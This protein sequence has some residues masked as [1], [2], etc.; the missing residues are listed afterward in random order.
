MLL[1]TLDDLQMAFTEAG[2]PELFNDMRQH[3]RNSIVIEVDSVFDTQALLTGMADLA[4]IL[5]FVSLSFLCVKTPIQYRSGALI[6][7]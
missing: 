6:L 1:R 3:A 5:I 4:V 7:R 2:L